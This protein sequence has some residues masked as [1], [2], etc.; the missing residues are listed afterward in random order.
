MI[1]RYETTVGEMSGTITDWV[2]TDLVT[3]SRID[4]DVTTESWTNFDGVTND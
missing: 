2:A 4:T 3:M 1:G